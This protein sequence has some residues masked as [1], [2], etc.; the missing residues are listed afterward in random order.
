[1]TKKPEAAHL[2]READAQVEL[3]KIHDVTTP[4]LYFIEQKNQKPFRCLG[5]N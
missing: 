4:P 2:V 1:M 5:Y 3:T